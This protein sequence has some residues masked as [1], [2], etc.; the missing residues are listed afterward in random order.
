MFALV[1]QVMSV[2]YFRKS[3][4]MDS[5]KSSDAYFDLFISKFR[6]TGR[7]GDVNIGRLTEW[8]LF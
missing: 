6:T 4:I 8:E 1:F 2:A 3:G 5:M 7:N